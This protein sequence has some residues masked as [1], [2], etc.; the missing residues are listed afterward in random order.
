MPCPALGLPY[1]SLRL[2]LRAVVM[3]KAVVAD[4]RLWDEDEMRVWDGMGVWQ[5]QQREKKRVGFGWLL[6]KGLELSTV[7][8]MSA[9]RMGRK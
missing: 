3:G 4:V 2:I 7:C 8:M 5:K 9:A 6:G 1:L